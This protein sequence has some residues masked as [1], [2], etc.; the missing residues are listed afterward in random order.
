[1]G[2]V[3]PGY[4][5]ADHR[6]RGGPGCVPAA[7][8]ELSRRHCAPGAGRRVQG[9][10]H[11]AAAAAGDRMR[12]LITG[13]TGQD[14][15]YLSGQLIEAGHDVWGMV[16][17]QSRA[18]GFEYQPG[19][20]IVDGDMLDQS[21]LA[22]A[23]KSVR[24]DVVYNLAAITYVGMSWQQPTVMTEVT[25]LGVLRL[26]EAIRMVD[27]EI[28]LVHASSSEM[29][30]DSVPV[31]DESSPVNPRSPY[32][33]AKLFAHKTVVNYRESYGLRCCSAI[34]FNHES[35]RRGPEFVTQKVCTAAARGEKVTLGRTDTARDWGWA[36]DYM[37]A[38]PL[39]AERDIPRDYVLATMRTWT[40]AKLCELAYQNAGLDWREYVEVNAALRR[41]ADI[42]S[43]CGTYGRAAAWLNWKPEVSFP[44]IVAAM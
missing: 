37:R 40:V 9:P 1:M 22:D 35:P 31:I 23:L 8:V 30:G 18:R 2:T 16:R 38:L 3:H 14:G 32:G 27:P 13:V 29:F 28:R 34:M 15:Y 11:R 20:R 21:S 26:L 25:G 24:P 17:W 44:E 4:G 41:P 42:T 43:L 6:R 12:C 33:V 19:L 7:R 5:A 36:P 39:M 10:V